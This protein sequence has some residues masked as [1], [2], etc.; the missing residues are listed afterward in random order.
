MASRYVIRRDAAGFSVVD[1][2]TGEP[3]VLAMD[4]QTGLSEEDAQHLAALFNKRAEQGE[5]TLL[6]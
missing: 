6:Q 2:F 4:P 1:N 3:L 5:R